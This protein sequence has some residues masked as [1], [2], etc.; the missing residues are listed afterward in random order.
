[1]RKLGVM[2]LLIALMA[3][4]VLVSGC[5]LKEKAEEGQPTV[6]I[7]SEKPSEI[8]SLEITDMEKILFMAGE[9][10]YV[11]DADG[12]HLFRLSGND[13]AEY[14]TDSFNVSQDGIDQYRVFMYGLPM[15]LPDGMPL[16]FESFLA[17]FGKS[18]VFD[19]F[20]VWSPDGKKMVLI[21]YTPSLYNGL[22]SQPLSDNMI[23]MSKCPWGS[24]CIPATGS[25]TVDRGKMRVLTPDGTT[26]LTGEEWG[27]DDHP[28]WS[29]DGEK[30][31][32]LSGFEF[33]NSTLYVINADGTN[34]IMLTQGYD[35]RG[36]SYAWSPDGEKIAYVLGNYGSSDL[37]V[38]NADGTQKIWL[39]KNGWNPVWSPDGNK[40]VFQCGGHSFETTLCLKNFS[41]TKIEDI[42][43]TDKKSISAI[44]SS[45]G[46][47]IFYLSNNKSPWSGWEDRGIY[48]MNA[49]GTDKIKLTDM[50]DVKPPTLSPD[51][52]KIGYVT[53]DDLY[54]MNLDGT[55]QIRLIDKGVDKFV[56]SPDSER[57]AF[58]SYLEECPS[59]TN[60]TETTGM[61]TCFEYSDL[62]V[63]NINN[64]NLNLITR[65]RGKSAFNDIA[66]SSI[67]RLTEIE[68]GSIINQNKK[69]SYK[70]QKIQINPNDDIITIKGLKFHTS[71]L[72]AQ[73]VAKDQNKPL[74]VYFR[75]EEDFVKNFEGS[76]F[77]NQSVFKILNESFILVSIDARKQHNET[78]Y[79]KVRGFPTMIFLSSNGGEITRLLGY[80]DVQ[81]YLDIMNR[82]AKLKTRDET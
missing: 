70:S 34:K 1:M 47:K 32:Y 62:Y 49:D 81:E 52:K 3:T 43:L 16:S 25:G 64:G 20:R 69:T 24:V 53:N 63:A 79:F 28:V 18:R 37:Y 73:E 27:I 61:Y 44:W 65:L 55:N 38:V 54:V 60:S 36:S 22:S 40:I 10:L 30:I 33:T 72:I 56:W 75:A 45:D 82:I 11:I 67:S 74:F 57:I 50:S 51:G 5:I 8:T 39:S 9:G 4:A 23:A 71:F 13:R 26:N 6:T 12:S 76:I 78:I 21:D 19:K 31:A 48:V 14:V 66:W 80:H 46:K 15:L 29:P 59:K 58:H 2:A 77:T 35:P 42:V 68:S 7:P 41:R 17:A